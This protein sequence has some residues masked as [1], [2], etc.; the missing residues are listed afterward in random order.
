MRVCSLQADLKID[1]F[2]ELLQRIKRKD[3]EHG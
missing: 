3:R 1:F 2:I